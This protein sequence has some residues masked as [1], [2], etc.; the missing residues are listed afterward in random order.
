M[1]PVKT[2]KIQKLVNMHSSKPGVADR[3][4]EKMKEAMNELVGAIDSKVIAETKAANL[5]ICASFLEFLNIKKK[6]GILSLCE[7]GISTQ[8]AL[9]IGYCSR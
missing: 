5:L 4:I 1:G 9:S 3:D 7:N 2:Q 6:Y 8:V